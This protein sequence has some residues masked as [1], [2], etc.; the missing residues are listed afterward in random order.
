L[1]PP[2]QEYLI[3]RTMLFAWAKSDQL[4][5]HTGGDSR[6]IVTTLLQ[7]P[8]E[9]ERSPAA[10]KVFVP[11]A[12]VT[13]RRVLEGG[14][15]TPTTEASAPIK[16]DL[17]F[18]LPA[19]V[20]PLTLEKVTLVARVRAPGRVL[21]VSGLADGVPTALSTTESPVEPVRVEITD[22]K[23]LKLDEQGGLVLN[24]SIGNLPN[25]GGAVEAESRW[26][27]ESLTLEV[28]GQTK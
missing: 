15:T 8:L 26:K 3:D 9:F 20:L 27:I 11:R 17:R 28:V 18:Q 10:N 24:V 6:N 25:A 22:S 5:F 21:T 14:L 2:L 12:F 4:P 23:F 13:H 19:S 16:M 7:L 1:T